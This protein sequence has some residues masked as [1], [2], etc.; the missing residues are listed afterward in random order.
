MTTFAYVTVSSFVA[1]LSIT[2]IYGWIEGRD[3]RSIDAFH[4]SVRVKFLIPAAIESVP[5]VAEATFWDILS[6]EFS[7]VEM[8]SMSVVFRSSNFTIVA[9]N[10]WWRWVQ[11]LPSYRSLRIFQA[12]RAV[13]QPSTRSCASSSQLWMRTI[14][15]LSVR[16]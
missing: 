12:S 9:L 7:K 11:V 4:A 10:K 8:C 5:A 2:F 1:M 15:A 13:S 3:A 6:Q 14:R 16:F